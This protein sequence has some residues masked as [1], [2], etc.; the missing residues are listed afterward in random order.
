LHFNRE[1]TSHSLTTRLQHDLYTFQV[2]ESDHLTQ[3]HVWQSW[4]KSGQSAQWCQQHF[5]H[6]K[7]LRKVREIRAQLLD[8]MQQQK[9][10]V[11]S[12]G[13]DWD[14]VR[15]AICGSYV[16]NGAKLK[17]V[18]QVGAITLAFVNHC[19]FLTSFLLD[20]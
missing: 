15:R 6:I 17:G 13:S 10:A 1:L 18:G 5:I 3:L 12:C 7:A 20:M 16:H 4:R 14:P 2:P 8:I 19:F 11:N 9:V